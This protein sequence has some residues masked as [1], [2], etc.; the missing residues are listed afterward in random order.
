V[1]CYIEARKINNALFQGA[2]DEA[3]MDHRERL[4]QYARGRM[5]FQ[6]E[7]IR[8]F[9]KNFA[10]AKKYLLATS[11]VDPLADWDT[12]AGRVFFENN[13]SDIARGVKMARIFIEH[14]ETIG[15]LTGI[16][17]MH[18]ENNV[19]VAVVL[20]EEIGPELR[21]D[22]MVIDGELVGRFRLDGRKEIGYEI[23][24]GHDES[25][26]RDI[27]RAVDQFQQLAD[28]A[29]NPFDFAEQLQISE[30]KKD[31]CDRLFQD[32][33]QLARQASK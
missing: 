3:L 15:K 7:P 26:R 28:R 18:I 21:V 12:P 11:Y 22:L 1:H 20:Y 30:D 25:V 17:G 2:L 4:S 8:P 6:L 29:R 33:R 10:L 31:L 19:P 23:C 14:Q 16:I 9:Q 13:L 24:V 32:L 5:T 27:S